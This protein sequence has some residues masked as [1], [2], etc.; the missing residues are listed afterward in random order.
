LAFLL[1]GA[2]VG[3]LPVSLASA[4]SVVFLLFRWHPRCASRRKRCPCAGRHLLFFAA[5]KKSRQKKA[6]Q[7]EPLDSFYLDVKAQAAANGV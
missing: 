5:A 3:L 2:L 4:I 7:T 1:R 6:A